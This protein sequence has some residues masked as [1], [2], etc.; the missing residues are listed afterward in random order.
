MLT[1]PCAPAVPDCLP[2]RKALPSQSVQT[3]LL[4]QD[5][6]TRQ[7]HFLNPSAVVIWEACDGETTVGEC[8]ARLRAAFD[9]PDGV[10]LAADI[11][12]TLRDFRRNGLIP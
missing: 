4:I 6:V 5:P 12:E 8:A 2:R 1:S 7:V 11:Q 10:D 9:I 3:E